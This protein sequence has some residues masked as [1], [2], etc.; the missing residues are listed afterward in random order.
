MINLATYFT[1]YHSAAP[2][3]VSFC[4]QGDFQASWEAKQGPSKAGFFILISHHSLPSF[5]PLG[6]GMFEHRCSPVDVPGAS[7]FL[8]LFTLKGSLPSAPGHSHIKPLPSPQI[9]Y[10]APASLHFRDDL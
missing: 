4:P 1:T 9:T 10:S 6:T 5:D 8:R 2:A 3:K 7:V